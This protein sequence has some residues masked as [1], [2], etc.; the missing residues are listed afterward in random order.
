MTLEDVI[1][2]ALQWPEVTVRLKEALSSDLVV[3]GPY[4]RQICERL[5]EF[6]DE[7]EALPKKGDWTAWLETLDD[8]D[9]EGVR[10][11]LQD[12]WGRDLS[13]YTPDFVAQHAAD[14]LKK[15][16][17]QNAISRLN[18][19]EGETAPEAI[20]EMAERIEEIEPVGLDGLADLRN[21][22]RWLRPER[23]EDAISTGID[24][25]DQ[26]IRGWRD[27][28]VMLLADTK[29]GKSIALA[30]FG[31]TAALH[32]HKVFHL[33]LEIDRRPQ[34]RRYYRRMT[35]TDRPTLH[36]ET[37]RVRKEAKDWWS[38]AQ[39]EL[40]LVRR[41]AHEITPEDFRRMIE[42]HSRV[43]WK[44]DLVI[45]DY[46]DL[47]APS[48]SINSRRTYEQ[49]GHASHHVRDNCKIFDCGVL[50]ATQ[51]SRPS[52]DYIERLSLADMGDSY[53]KVRAA[54]MVIGLVQTPDEAKNSRARIQLLAVRDAPGEGA[55]INVFFEKDLMYLSDLD[56]PNTRRIMNELGYDVPELDDDDDDA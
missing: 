41:P 47:L 46:L 38:W 56:T 25:L 2:A 50:T 42:I 1:A 23:E 20:R 30:N 11:A 7:H 10:E 29:V 8:R 21:V 14:E 12:L 40:H 3:A 35:E 15:A 51:A 54:D 31:H 37:E 16:A 34:A 52:G 28:L 53:K 33:S 36:S 44:P 45:L 9:R 6:Y 26:Y 39:G 24:S 13:G 22:D 49:L 43:H 5:S 18:R 4:Q 55:E 27:E 19:V 32:G 17:A 48:P